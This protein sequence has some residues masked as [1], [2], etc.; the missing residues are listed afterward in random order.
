MLSQTESRLQVRSSELHV[1][2]GHAAAT[3]VCAPR[4]GWVQVT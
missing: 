2:A 1:E 3:F 4:D